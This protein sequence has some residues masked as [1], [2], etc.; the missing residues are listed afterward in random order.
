MGQKGLGSQNE[1]E[2]G[3]RL[4]SLRSDFGDG[5][6]GGDMAGLG[7]AGGDVVRRGVVPSCPHAGSEGCHVVQHSGH[8]GLKCRLRAK[9]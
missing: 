7:D 5:K 9:S 3:K 6:E 1:A 2:L 4:G 8:P